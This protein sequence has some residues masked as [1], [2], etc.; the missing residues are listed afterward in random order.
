MV[1]LLGDLK[2]PKFHSEINCPLQRINSFYSRYSCQNT[3]SL[4]LLSGLFFE[5]KKPSIDL[6]RTFTSAKSFANSIS[7]QRLKVQTLQKSQ[8]SGLN[9]ESR[10]AKSLYVSPWVRYLYYSSDKIRKTQN[11][12]L[13]IV[14]QNLLGLQSRI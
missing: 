2:T 4:F 9:G 1:G 14:C 13:I 5:Q 10:L 7:P 3:Y 8:S 11:E 6:S 12:P